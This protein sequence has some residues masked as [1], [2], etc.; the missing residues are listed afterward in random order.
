MSYSS[1]Y[2]DLK[3]YEPNIAC[4]AAGRDLSVLGVSRFYSEHRDLGEF[5]AERKVI[6]I[7]DSKY[8]KMFRAHFLD[9]KRTHRSHIVHLPST[10]SET[11]YDRGSNKMG[12]QTSKKGHKI[13]F[14]KFIN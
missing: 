5:D 13:D 2:V 3:K 14:R 9:H 6:V 11:I 12:R 1:Q 7:R 8:C 10:P 4:S